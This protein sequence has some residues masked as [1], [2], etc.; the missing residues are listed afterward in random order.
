MNGAVKL[1]QMGSSLSTVT[2]I[3]QTVLYVT[4]SLGFIQGLGDIAFPSLALV[5]LSAQ[6]ASGLHY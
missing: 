3:E 4:C 2:D 1:T 6:V 5:A